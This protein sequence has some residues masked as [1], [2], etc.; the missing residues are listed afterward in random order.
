MRW[1]SGVVLCLAGCATLPGTL[2]EAVRAN[3]RCDYKA[4][5]LLVGQSALA[6][7]HCYVPIPCQE[8]PSLDAQV[9]CAPP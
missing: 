5:Y 2:D 8:W 3:P 6:E 9:Q 4:P 7:Y 1:L